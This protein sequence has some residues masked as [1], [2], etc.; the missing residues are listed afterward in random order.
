MA[1]LH[2]KRL[3]LLCTAVLACCGVVYFVPKNAGLLIE[4]VQGGPPRDIIAD[5][6]KQGESTEYMR[7]PVVMF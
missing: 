1:T 5:G 4:Q 6:T 3:L 7:L 2:V